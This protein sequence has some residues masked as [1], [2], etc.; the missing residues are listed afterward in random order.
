MKSIIFVL[1]CVLLSSIS[2]QDIILENPIL[3]YWGD[4]YEWQNCSEGQYIHGMRLMTHEYQTILYDDT[5]LN[6]IRLYCGE[7]GWSSIDEH[8]QS[9]IGDYGTFQLNFMCPIGGFMTGFQMNS[10]EA[11]NLLDDTAGN[12]I[13]MFCN[14]ETSAYI[15]GD[16]LEIGTWTA[17]RH[18]P[19]GA[20]LCGISTQIEASGTTDDSSLNNFKVKCCPITNPAKT[21]EPSDAWERVK[22]CDNTKGSSPKACK[23]EKRVGV[24]YS[25]KMSSKPSERTFYNNAGYKLD[26]QMISELSQNIQSK[27][28][29]SNTINWEMETGFYTM[30]NAVIDEISIPAHSHMTLYQAVSQCGI[31]SAS[32]NTYKKVLTNKLSKSETVSYIKV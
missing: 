17:A 20:A 2:G 9:G 21:C 8:V 31:F 4:W 22:I 23:F 7:P 27:M 10:E 19:A 3:T 18:C 5:A 30:E 24:A 29:S 25:H 15:Q 16:G 14:G 6:G 13:R 11:Q 1:G 32:S 26:D 12:N 28:T